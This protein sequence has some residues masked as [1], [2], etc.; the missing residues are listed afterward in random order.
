MESA[1]RAAR[2]ARDGAVRPYGADR[3]YRFDQHETSGPSRVP[4]R[5]AGVRGGLRPDRRSRGL[6]R[7][8]A[9]GVVGDRDRI[10]AF[11]RPVD[12]PDITPSVADLRRLGLS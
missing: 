8:R 4:A 9:A 3:L 2:S 7:A 5:T 6:D 1:A 12:A 11:A 10:S